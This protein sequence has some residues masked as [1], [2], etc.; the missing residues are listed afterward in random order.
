MA[1][2]QPFGVDLSNAKFESNEPEGNGG[3][4]AAPSGSEAP[5][6][7][8]FKP[9]AKAEETSG[10]QDKVQ[11]PQRELSK[12]EIERLLGLETQQKNDFKKYDDNFGF[13]IAVLLKD[14][15][16]F[17]R[18]A[19]IYPEAYVERARQILAANGVN[20]F[21]PQDAPKSTPTNDP[22]SDPRIQKALEMADKFEAMQKEQRIE[23]I[24][25]KLDKAF[26]SLASKYPDADKN[27]VN[28]YLQG[29]AQKGISLMDEKG[30]LRTQIL[31][32]LFK[33]DHDAR[34]AAYEKKYRSLVDNQKNVNR[35][36]KDMGSGGSLSSIPGKEARTI[37]DATKMLLSDIR[38]AK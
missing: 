11:E 26:D 32:R 23:A 37:K 3:G 27:V 34:N 14:P 36:A 20:P 28:W 35:R 25:H 1:E 7:E 33:S 29:L 30:N 5:T 12:D 2:H 9:E 38:A 31:E 15:K 10:A 21:Q 17:N 16:Q 18:F 6:G 8:A 24:G 13:D 4:A 19:Q 22:W